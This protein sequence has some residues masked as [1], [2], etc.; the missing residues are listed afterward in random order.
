LGLFVCGV[1]I[2]VAVYLV[3]GDCLV[4]PVF[5]RCSSCGGL[6]PVG[7]EVEPGGEIICVFCGFLFN[8]PVE[9]VD[10]VVERKRGRDKKKRQRAVKP[11]NRNM[12][13]PLL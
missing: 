12:R 8:A 7:S 13:K 3:G 10:E 4:G 1:F 11:V 6:N 5:L 2:M 9:P